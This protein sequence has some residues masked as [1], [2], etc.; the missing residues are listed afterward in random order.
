M[1][2]MEASHVIMYD[3]RDLCWNKY[4]PYYVVRKED[5]FVLVQHTRVYLC[6]G[7]NDSACTDVC[8]HEYYSTFKGVMDIA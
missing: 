6:L 4:E 8:K 2:L 3:I 5:F 7:Y 1:E